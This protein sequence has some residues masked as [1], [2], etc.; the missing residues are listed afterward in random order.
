MVSKADLGKKHVL[1]EMFGNLL[2]FW[3]GKCVFFLMEKG[4]LIFKSDLR[5]VSFNLRSVGNTNYP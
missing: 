5:R 1:I 4:K 2:A 3:V